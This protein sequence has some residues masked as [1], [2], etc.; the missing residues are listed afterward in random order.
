MDL[1]YIFHISFFL[2]FV[3]E[4]KMEELKLLICTIYDKKNNKFEEL[5]EKFQ[6]L[7][8]KYIRILY[9]DEKEDVHSELVLALW[10]AVINIKYVENEGQIM[11][12]L[13]RA[14]HNKFLELYR[15]SRNLHDA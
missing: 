9:K 4:K 3:E 1:V 2:P 14:L 7:I 15:K 10:E 8:K 13:C 12:Y 6:P 11:S 5:V